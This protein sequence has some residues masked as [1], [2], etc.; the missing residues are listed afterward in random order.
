MWGLSNSKSPR[1]RKAIC[2][3]INMS[4]Y[5]LDISDKVHRRV[6]IHGVSVNM[7]SNSL[8]FQPLEWNKCAKEGPGTTRAPGQSLENIASSVPDAYRHNLLENNTTRP[9]ASLV[10]VLKDST[11]SPRRDAASTHRLQA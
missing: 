5:C 7:E 10:P 1:Q 8:E 4:Q 3:I 2:E 9:H 6:D 11:T